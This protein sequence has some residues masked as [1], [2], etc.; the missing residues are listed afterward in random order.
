MSESARTEHKYARLEYE[1]RFLVDRLPPEVRVTRVRQINDRY[2]DGTTLR[3]REQVEKDSPGVFKL[4]QKLPTS[5]ASVQER[6]ITTIYITQSEFKVLA[7][8]PAKTLTKIRHSVP[9]F[10][11]DV[12]HGTLKGLVLAE[13]EFDSPVRAGAL[14]L[15]AFLRREVSSDER[16]TG[17]RLVRASR[18]ELQNWVAE[19]QVT[20]QDV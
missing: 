3:L 20:L 14:V 16:F 12:F 10:G 17:G 5:A 18:E 15:P 1:R 8:L 11:I 7:Q 13:A 2:I 19:Y 4:T 6:V 9:P